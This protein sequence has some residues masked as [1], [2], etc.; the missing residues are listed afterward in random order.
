MK[1]VRINI[2]LLFFLSSLLSFAQTGNEVQG[3]GAG[4]NI[5]TADYITLYGDSAGYSLTSGSYNILLGYKAGKSFDSETDNI[6]I[7][8]EAADQT[9][10]G[11]D[12][13][14]IGKW[15]ARAC[16]G[17]DNTVIGTEAGQNMNGYANDN[18]IIGEEAGEFLSDG[19]DNTFVGED[20]GRGGWGSDINSGSDNT[21][22]GSASGL[23]NT[24]GFRNCFVGS[25]SGYDNT[26]GYRNT[27]V[28]DS[29]GI[30]GSIGHHNTFIGQAAGPATEYASYNTFVGSYS[31]WDNNRTNINNFSDGMRNTYLGYRAGYTNREGKENIVIGSDADFG[32]V[33]YTTN[34]YNV[35]IGTYAKL[36]A[37]N[38][39]NNVLL[40]HGA[41]INKNNAIAIGYSSDISG[42]A[43]IGIGTEVDIDNQNAIGIGYQTQV[44][45][46]YS[47]AFGYQ[48]I[49]TAD[50]SV[51]IGFDNTLSG[52]NTFAFGNNI[53]SSA[54]NSILLGGTARHMTVGI[55][56]VDPNQNASLDLAES[57]KGFLVSRMNQTEITAYESGL[58]TTEEGMMLFDTEN[59]LL[60]VWSGDSWSQITNVDQ[61]LLIRDDTLEISNSNYVSLKPYLDNTDSQD[62]TLTSNTLS[63]TGDDSTVDLSAY[64]DNTDNQNLSFTS[65]SLSIDNGNSIDLSAYLD[66]TDAQNLSAATLTGTMLQ[67]DIDNG[68][69]AS[70]DLADLQDGIG[71]DDQTLTLTN[72][73]LSIEDGNA[74]DLGVFLDNTDAQNLSAA[75]LTGTMLQIDIDNGNS[76]SVDLAPLQAG[77]GTDNQNLTAATLVETTLTIEIEDGTS[78]SVDLAPLLTE[79]NTILADHETRIQ[80]MEAEI[81]WLK[82]F[83]ETT[84]IGDDPEKSGALLYQNIPNPA[85]GTTRIQ[86]YLPL[87][88]KQASLFVYDLEGRLIAKQELADRGIGFYE[89]EKHNLKPATYFYSLVVENRKVDTK[90]MVLV[91]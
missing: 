90:R 50:S 74:I 8:A 60:K 2:L 61:S 70:V 65:N 6:V 75:T 21:F 47:I 45:G 27:F 19:D 44:Q 1:S 38:L 53:T 73:S 55:G 88:I 28:G 52:A 86:Y 26:S 71:T 5:T 51:T 11:Y 17:T 49:I 62:L 31:G 48:D 37:D 34:N 81:A 3:T 15:V 66:N 79:V 9:S 91:D 36:Y 24:S 57:D 18:T 20:A 46:D 40:G 64:L 77:E 87:E 12:N 84:A 30:D 7:G 25:E 89:I 29:A 83:H 4:V 63:L 56:T 13:I 23:N 54:T 68:T 14:Y 78:V 72:S 80:D 35:I 82:T 42:T 22:L 33:G 76:A 67:I 58:T 43:S 69:S 39:S 85:N 41:R 10:T 59:D 16:T 32:G